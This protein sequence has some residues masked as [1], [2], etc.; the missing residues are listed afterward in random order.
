MLSGG[1][2]VPTPFVPYYPQGAQIFPHIFQSR[3][4]RQEK[5]KDVPKVTWLVHNRVNGHRLLRGL[6]NA[7]TGLPALSTPQDQVVNDL[8][9][10]TPKGRTGPRI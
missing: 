2:G 1:L 5:G 8:L 10:V 4:L 9:W 7:E 6:L 3:K